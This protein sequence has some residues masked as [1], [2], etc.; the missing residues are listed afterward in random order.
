M[1]LQVDGIGNLVELNGRFAAELDSPV[2]MVSCGCT[3]S[4]P[5]NCP[6]TISPLYTSLCSD[7]TMHCIAATRS[8]PASYN[9]C[10]CYP[11]PHTT[12]IPK[13]L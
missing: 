10:C 9:A 12:P 7:S 13:M 5:A 4:L 1:P 3:F 8:P 6:I 2:L 11:A